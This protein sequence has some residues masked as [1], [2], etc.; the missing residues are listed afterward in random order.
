M[1]KKLKL[2][3][4]GSRD[5]VMKIE[6]EEKRGIVLPEDVAKD[7]DYVR[8][9]VVEVGTDMEKIKVQ[10]GDKVILSGNYAGTKIE[11]EGEELFIVK[12]SEILATIE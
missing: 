10:K 9:E 2:K 6:E 4:L 12:S 11:V 8:A 7:E 5:L 3:P 1:A